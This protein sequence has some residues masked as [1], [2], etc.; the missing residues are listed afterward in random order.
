MIE[1]RQ[2][3]KSNVND[4]SDGA[5]AENGKNLSILDQAFPL[6]KGSPKN[7]AP[8]LTFPE[9][10]ANIE[11]LDSKI[12][13]NLCEA[14]FVS[15]GNLGRHMRNVHKTKIEKKRDSDSQCLNE[16][17]N[18]I[19]DSTEPMIE[20]VDVN[21][22]VKVKI[23]EN[24]ADNPIYNGDLLNS[25]KCNLCDASFTRSSNLNRHII[26]QHPDTVGDT[27]VFKC[28]LCDHTFTKASSL[29]FH[30][31]MKHKAQEK[32]EEKLLISRS[33]F[34]KKTDQNHTH[35]LKKQAK[36]KEREGEEKKEDLL[37][38]EPSSLDL[39]DVSLELDDECDTSQD[40][41][42]STERKVLSKEGLKA[43]NQKKAEIMEKSEYFSAGRPGSRIQGWLGC[44]EDL[45][46]AE[47][48]PSNFCVKHCVTSSGRRY[49]EY[50]TPDREFK[51]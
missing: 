36:K 40:S 6:G 4:N 49:S 42:R 19:N 13:C 5:A 33:L 2:E 20:D 39:S 45:V 51:L 14:T 32:C 37:L 48:L 22:F 10:V 17:E 27:A 43:L 25:H 15:K 11:E 18:E 31:T 12:E 28:D 3:T 38:K 26:T 30:S 46:Q 34:T 23:E 44:E 50:V 29:K 21:N 7:S 9:P 8:Q 24:K 41:S 35:A 1:E 16:R 47:N